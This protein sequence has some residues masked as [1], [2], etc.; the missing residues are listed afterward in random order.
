MV[1]DLPSASVFRSKKGKT[2]NHDEIPEVVYDRG[3]P[4]ARQLIK[5]GGPVKDEIM[6]MNHLLITIETHS[7]DKNADGA[8]R[9]VGFE[10]EAKSV[11]WGEK[12]CLR[13]ADLDSYGPQ[14]YDPESKVSYTF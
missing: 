11:A 4:V 2:T 3:I 5:Q 6:V 8:I 1:D 13:G 9:I 7:V 10:V 14:L 12:P